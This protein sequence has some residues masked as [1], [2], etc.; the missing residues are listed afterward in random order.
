MYA[1]GPALA[2]STVSKY[3]AMNYAVGPRYTRNLTPPQVENVGYT[4]KA[5]RVGLP[6]VTSL[7]FVSCTCQISIYLVVCR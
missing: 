4:L 2:F 6:W 3:P 1:V 7:K 5:A